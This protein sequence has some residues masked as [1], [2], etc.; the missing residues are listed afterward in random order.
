MSDIATPAAAPAAPAP[1]PAAKAPAPA[2]TK[3]PAAEPVR[4]SPADF[5]A[6]LQQGA[7][8]MDDSDFETP[9]TTESVTSNI[10]DV[11]A[12]EQ[13][14]TH[15][16]EDFEEAA[17]EEEVP[18]EDNSWLEELKDFREL[19][20]LSAKEILAALQQGMLPDALL[21]KIKIKLKDG[22]HE[23]D[24]TL[25]DARNS[26]MLRSNYTKKLQAH[27]DLKKAF[28]AEKN[29]FNSER[30]A[31]VGLLKGWKGDGKALL[32]GL[33]AMEFPVLEMAQALAQELQE[34]EEMGP[35]ARNLYEA[36]QK[37]EQQAELNRLELEKARREHQMYLDSQKTKTEEVSNDQI[38]SGVREFAP[39][40][41]KEMNLAITEGTWNIFTEQL[42]A[43][44]REHGTPNKEMVRFAIQATKEIVDQHLAKHTAAPAP[45]QKPAQKVSIPRLDGG[46]PA[47]TNRPGSKAGP[48]TPAQFR[49]KIL[50]GG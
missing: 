19:H 5:R 20:G 16:P 3:A 45:V 36:K 12:S 47:A 29:G 37:A 7:Y 34:L 28:E 17:P 32:S 46:K 4:K 30:E 23:W 49:A 25:A 35:A 38:I 13:E 41:F 21:D 33:R 11:E 50:A 48:L 44:W 27:S 8:D 40:V 31:F 6:S 43:M 26:A 1:T 22:D 42:G 9:E 14:D 39:S 10:P 2:A 18:E 15:S 24:A